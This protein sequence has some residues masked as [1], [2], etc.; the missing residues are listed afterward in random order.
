MSSLSSLLPHGDI[1]NMEYDS[2]E[3]LSRRRR[4]AV[5]CDHCRRRKMRCDGIQPVCTYCSNHGIACVYQR[6]SQKILVSKHYLDSIT[7]ELE[8]LRR[9]KARLVNKSSVDS[10]TSSGPLMSP[11][12]PVPQDASPLF[13]SSPGRTRALKKSNLSH[14]ESV[15]NES[16]SPND[17]IVCT[18][19]PPPAGGSYF[20]GSSTLAFLEVLQTIAFRNGVEIPQRYHSSEHHVQN[21]I[22]ES[23]C[24]GPFRPTSNIKLKFLPPRFTAD[25]LVET[26]FSYVTDMYTVLHEP[27]FREEY[28]EVWRSGSEPDDLWFCILN[29]VFA[30]GSLFSDRLTPE[31]SESTSKSF[32]SQAKDLFNFDNIDYG[33]LAM[34]QALLL[35]GQYLHIRRLTRCWHV[36]G[37]AIRVAQGLGLQLSD[38]NDKCGPVERET[39]KRCWCG[40]MIM[41]TMLGMTFGRPMM[42]HSQ[43]YHNAEIPEPV[44]DAPHVPRQQEVGMT[45]KI[46][47]F[48]NRFKLC[49]ILHDILQAL[50]QATADDKE[51]IFDAEEMS[52]FDKRLCAWKDN[53]PASMRMMDSSQDMVCESSSMRPRYML[54]TRYLLVRILLTRPSLAVVASMASPTAAKKLTTLDQTFALSAAEACIDTSSQLIDY[55]HTN[56]HIEHVAWNS[57]HSIFSASLVLF[58]AQL[59]PVL[60][61]RMLENRQ[62][63]GSIEV[64]RYLSQK[65]SSAQACLS[66][67]EGLNHCSSEFRGKQ[68]SVVR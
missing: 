29:T 62:W 58:A 32:F 63:E 36:F 30:L 15:S 48:I 50:Y 39:R 2:T 37:I 44:D 18:R 56:L 9:K 53:L 46:L 54:Y 49:V 5:A 34:V 10:S 23:T 66:M 59:I 52:K 8:E 20:G 7:K 64:M 47:L 51:A 21:E 6:M 26:Y 25:H 17:T 4:V 67:L 41:D 60:K 42:I 27:T 57:T 12:S 45:P 19:A 22:R 55:I 28:E 31:A 16:Q 38:I 13:S 40:C 43:Y 33:S 35:M 3:P 1:F 68:T 24:P 65:C 14:E 61:P 11:P